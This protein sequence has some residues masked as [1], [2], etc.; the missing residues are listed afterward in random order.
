MKCA[1]GV[2]G[3]AAAAATVAAIAEAVALRHAGVETQTVL[4]RNVG[5]Q[6]VLKKVLLPTHAGVGTGVGPG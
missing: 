5:D 1:S 2:V 4:S 3:C 6:R